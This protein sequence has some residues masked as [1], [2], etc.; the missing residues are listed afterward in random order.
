M[1]RLPDLMLLLTRM[2]RSCVDEETALLQDTTLQHLLGAGRSQPEIRMYRLPD[3]MLLLT[4]IT[5]S[6]ESE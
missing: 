4:R 2:A 1:Y 5:T 3:L 6:G